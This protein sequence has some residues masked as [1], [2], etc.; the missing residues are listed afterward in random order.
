MSRSIK[1]NVSCHDVIVACRRLSTFIEQFVPLG[2]R[3]Q[4]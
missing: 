4:S 1:I 2:F 3:F